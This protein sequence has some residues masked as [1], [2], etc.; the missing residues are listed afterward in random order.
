MN[1]ELNSPEEV[2]QHIDRLKKARDLESYC[3]G[4]GDCCHASVRINKAKITVPELPCKFLMLKSNGQ[5]RCSVYEERFEKA[6]WC[7]D[8]FGGMIEG[9][10]PTTCN[11][12]KSMDAYAGSVELP[13][14]EYQV[15]RGF[16]Q[17]AIALSPDAEKTAECFHPEDYSAFMHSD[18]LKSVVFGPGEDSPY[19]W[20]QDNYARLPGGVRGMLSRKLEDK[21]PERAYFAKLGDHALIRSLI[22]KSIPE[23]G[24][25]LTSLEEILKSLSEQLDEPITENITQALDVVKSSRLITSRHQSYESVVFNRWLLEKAVSPDV[26]RIVDTAYWWRFDDT[27]IPKESALLGK[28]LELSELGVDSGDIHKSLEPSTK[29]HAVLSE[30]LNLFKTLS[31]L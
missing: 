9:T 18:L 6:P 21:S 4:C 17:K 26:M 5:Y 30:D 3:T 23:I 1:L 16:I 29:F 22:V 31:N 13:D 11:Y 12:T 25:E 8:L 28:A 20:V 14:E 15:V 24:D 10:Y 2:G 19:D 27:D 7:Q